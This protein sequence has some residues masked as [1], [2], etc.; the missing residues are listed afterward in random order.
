[1][2]VCEEVL[3][4]NR[5]RSRIT[6]RAQS[7]SPFYVMELLEKA[8]A[9]EASGE[10]VIHMEV[11]EPDFASPERV[12]EEAVRAIIENRTFYTHSLGLPE[13][14]TRIAKFYRE[15]E[16]VEVSPDRIVIANGTSG[17]L[18]LLFATL[19]DQRKEVAISDPGYPCYRN[20]GLL[21][22]AR[23]ASLPIS[24][25]TGFEVRPEHLDA[26]KKKPGVL[27]VSNP[28]NPT[29]IVYKEATIRQLFEAMSRSGG[30]LVV[31]EIYSG[32]TYGKKVGTALSI[33]D[34]I[35]VVNGFSKTFAMTGWR[36]G[37]MVVP[38]DL[39][40]PIQKIA[41]NVFISPP[42]ISQ[43]AALFAFD[44]RAE[45]EN[46]RK[47]YEKRRDFL[48]PRLRGLGF[49]IPIDP[50]GAFYIYAGITK[51]GQDSMKFSNRALNEAKVAFTPGYDFGS[52]L[53]GTHVRFSYATSLEMLEEGCDRLE[54]WLETM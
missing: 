19:L 2:K 47:T 5:N 36:L 42:S 7:I 27:V 13:L 44:A 4:G 43:H 23:I 38:D 49:T 34:D 52:F 3:M 18:L 50:Q 14:R 31:D 15:E 33:S 26:L 37:W 51:W 28:S 30:T 16:R 35:V 32:L 22:G 53:A 10:R 20:F 25:E 6:G 24:E 9:L 40:R 29:G 12:K 8:K 21:V 17:A 45:L 39:V 11:G 1:M 41:Q 54:K 48:L 46:M